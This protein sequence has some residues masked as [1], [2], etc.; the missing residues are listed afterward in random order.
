VQAKA[1]LLYQV[2]LRFG[3]TVFDEPPNFLIA[4]SA[5]FAVW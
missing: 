4:F 3:K 5:L 2:V 1:F